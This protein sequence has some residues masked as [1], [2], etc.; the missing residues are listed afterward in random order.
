[1]QKARVAVDRRRQQRGVTAIMMTFVI[2][3]VLVAIAAA[4]V[5]ILTA[6]TREVGYR[7]QEKQALYLAQ[8]GIEKATTTLQSSIESYYATTLDVILTLEMIDCQVGTYPASEEALGSG[9]FTVQITSIEVPAEFDRRNITFRATGSVGGVTKTVLSVKTFGFSASKV[10]DSTYFINNYGWF[11]G[12]A[13]QF[14]GDVRANGNFVVQGAQKINGDVYASGTIDESA[15]SFFYDSLDRYY[16]TASTRARPGDPPAPGE[17]EFAGG[18]DGFADG[19]DSYGDPRDTETP[20]QHPDQDVVDMPY[21]GDLDYYQNLAIEENGTVKIDGATIINNNYT[22]TV[23]L[24]G[25][26]TSPIV[27]DGPVVVSDDVIIKGVVSGQGTIYAGRNV[28]IIADISYQNPPSWPKPDYDP[29]DTADENVDKD[30]LCLS[31]KG[32]VVLGDYNHSGWAVVKDYIQPPFTSA[33]A[34]DATDA[35]N[36]YVSYYSDGTPYFDGNYTDYDGGAK[37]DGASRKFYESSLSD[38]Q[39]SSY[40]PTIRIDQIDALVYTNHLVGGR[41]NNMN[42]NGSVIGRD[43]GI[44]FTGSLTM[45]YDYRVRE[46]G[47]EYVNINLPLSVM[48]PEEVSWR[49]E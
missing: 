45:N 7:G 19:Y 32:N 24:V 3:I 21:L 1:M 46:Q 11:Y 43:D 6:E 35:G 28:H 22:G 42:F 36:G 14:Q 8:A 49:E 16:T 10:F 13:Q 34:V 31:A 41:V 15:G 27:I 29:E 9:T 44:A 12:G 5:Y 17:A 47:R 26:S 48:D 40:S 2:S 39:F 4:L 38:T 37:S 20:Q 18:Y 30:F 25:T 23:V 33:Y